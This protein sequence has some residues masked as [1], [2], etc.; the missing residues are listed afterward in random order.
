MSQDITDEGSTAAPAKEMGCSAVRDVLAVVAGNALEYY[1]F[2]IYAYF[3]IFIG[4]AFFPAL[5]QS[6]Q[7]IAAVAVFGAGFVARPVGGVIIGAYA[8][9]RGRK[10]A[11]TL[12]F[13]LMALGTAVIAFTPGYDS[14][15]FA[16]PI[17]VTLGRLTQGFSAGGETGAA[18]SFLLERGGVGRKGLFTS[19]QLATQGVAALFGGGVG[20]LVSSIL[21]PQALSDWGWRLPFAVGLIIAPIGIHIRGRLHETLSHART[22]HGTGEL[23]Q[24]I[25]AGHMTNLL[26]ACGVIVGPAVSTQVISHYMTTYAMRVL[27]LPTST[28]MLVG[29]ISGVVGFAGAIAAGIYFDR[30]STSKA[31][32]IPQ[33]LAAALAVPLFIWT[34]HAGTGFALLVTVGFMTLF[35]VLMSPFHLCVIPEMFPAEIR[36]TSISFVYSITPTIFGGSAQVIIAWLA[37]LYR[38]P[39]TPAWYVTGANV[40]SLIAV[41]VLF[42]RYRRKRS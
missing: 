19:W 33:L 5:S 16:A 12:T 28:S 30:Y 32:T 18:T 6:A 42:I 15:G 10:A 17:L 40:V 24:R 11:L 26:L 27:H 31:L 29:L 20:Y 21:S 9:R 38:D 7:L 8:D 4:H 35:R 23:I 25:R 13:G 1:D 36:S 22:V 3:S 39:M 41:W 34:L 37:S 2:T 14:I